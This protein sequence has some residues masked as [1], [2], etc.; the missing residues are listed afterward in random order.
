MRLESLGTTVSA[1]EMMAQSYSFGIGVLRIVEGR[2]GEKSGFAERTLDRL[3]AVVVIGQKPL[4]CPPRAAS[5][6][7][8]A[9]TAFIITKALGLRMLRS[10]SFSGAR[11]ATRSGNARNEYLYSADISI[12]GTARQHG[13]EAFIRRRFSPRATT[14]FDR[15]PLCFGALPC[16]I[17]FSRGGWNGSYG[18][19]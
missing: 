17:V 18:T 4:F 3:S 8:N 10:T 19:T 2:V 14:V 5:T 12:L 1:D 11:C 6:I 9:P 7:W 15:W 16:Q 13:L